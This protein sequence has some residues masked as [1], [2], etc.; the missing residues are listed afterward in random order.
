[1]LGRLALCVVAFWCACAHPGPLKTAHVAAQP[2]WVF[3]VDCDALRPTRVGDYFL[4]EIQKAAIQTKLAGFPVMFELDPGKRLHGLTLYSI[5]PYEDDPVLLV[6]GEAS[7]KTFGAAAAA[8]TGYIAYKHRR[9]T[10]H[11][12]TYPHKRET[13][14]VY[15][16]IHGSIAVYGR[17]AQNVVAALDVLDGGASLKQT[18][19]F[20]HLTRSK[21]PVVGASGPFQV[22]ES[23]PGASMLKFAKA[24]R[25]ELAEANQRVKATWTVE[26]SSNQAA[27]NVVSLAPGLRLILR[28]QSRK[29]ELA[30]LA[31]HAVLSQSGA[32][33]VCS[34]DLTTADAIDLLKEL[35]AR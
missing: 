1:M 9:L 10:V 18:A 24:S 35:V 34:W 16:A 29:P 15:A 4:A 11:S 5:G 27:A 13:R 19:V 30:K 22:D 23:Q 25:F 21:A 6:Y 7:A 28:L 2:Q 32:D 33:A 8:R 3:H 26:T 14:R 12:W 17:V 31:E 20:P